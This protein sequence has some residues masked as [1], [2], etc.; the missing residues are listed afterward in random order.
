MQTVQHE[1]R[2]EDKSKVVLLLPSTLLTVILQNINPIK[3]N[4]FKKKKTFRE[5][6][7]DLSHLFA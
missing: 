4:K 7:G 2:P 5:P 1:K 3:I 6:Y